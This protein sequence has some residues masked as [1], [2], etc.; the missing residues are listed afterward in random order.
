M[1][2]PSYFPISSAEWFQFSY[3]R[4]GYVCQV[5]FFVFSEFQLRSESTFVYLSRACEVL[6]SSCSIFQWPSNVLAFLFWLYISWLPSFFFFDLY[7]FSL[8]WFCVP[9]ELLGMFYYHRGDTCHTLPKKEKKLAQICTLNRAPPLMYDS[10]SCNSIHP[11]PTN[12]LQWNTS[13]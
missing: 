2:S 7:H 11:S 13:K 5:F 9:N 12:P 1:F 6:F 8:T 10:M 4:T 3:T